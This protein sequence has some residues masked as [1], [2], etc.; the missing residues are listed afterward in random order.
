MNTQ[1]PPI[2]FTDYD[3]RAEGAETSNNS[4]NRKGSHF[5]VC[6]NQGPGFLCGLIIIRLFSFLTHF[7]SDQYGKT[8]Y[9]GRFSWPSML[10]LF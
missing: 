5:I 2:L 9:S 6:N 1:T 4:S 3:S 8:F 7:L 10:T